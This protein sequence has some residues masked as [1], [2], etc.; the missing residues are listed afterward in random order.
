M[1]ASSST[2]TP[3]TTPSSTTTR[4]LSVLADRHSASTPACGLPTSSL[5]PVRRPTIGTRPL[6]LRS[7]VSA[8]ST[9]SSTTTP[10]AKPFRSPP[11]TSVATA[12][13]SRELYA[14]DTWKVT[15]S[16]TLS[17]GVNWQYFSVPYETKG[18]ESVAQIVPGSGS[19]RSVHLRQVLQRT[20]HAERSRITRPCAVPLIQYVLGGKANNGP[21]LYAPEWH[22]FAPRFAFAYSPSWDR[23]TVLN[24]GLGMVYDRT[25]I[26]AVQYQQDQHSYLF[27]QSITQANGVPRTQGLRWRPILASAPTQPTSHPVLRRRRHVRSFPFA[28][29]R[30][31]RRPWPGFTVRLAERQRLQHHDRFALQDAVQHHRQLR[32]AA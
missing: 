12:T 21:A 22:D 7:V 20:R 16:L 28:N 3:P 1:A 26:N 8:R 23:K 31:M 2:S 32:H 25:I 4:R 13:T 19:A 27:Q 5:P 15:P 17:Y 18:L 6:P 24:G 9:S 10:P 11:A 29:A 14:G 30:A